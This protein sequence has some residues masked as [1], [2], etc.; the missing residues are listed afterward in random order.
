MDCWPEFSEAV[1]DYY[2]VKK[3]SFSYIKTSQQQMCL[4]MDDIDGKLTLYALNDYPNDVDFTYKVIDAKT[5]LVIADGS[6]I[7]EADISK[8][9]IQI[10]K[11][12]ENS[13][14][15]IEWEIKDLNN[16][17]IIGSNHYLS[18]E[19]QV[20]YKWY[21]DVMKIMDDYQFNGFS[22]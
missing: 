2:F 10:D 15:K 12:T 17:T 4:A 5:G 14:H 8:N 18:F 21:K 20:S 22:N 13:F 11:P 16:K 7:V 9:I 1:V 6:A 19:S 3:L